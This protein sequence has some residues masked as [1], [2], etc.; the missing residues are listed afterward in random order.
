[1][2]ET[3]G[4]PVDSGPS[5]DT[6]DLTDPRLTVIGLLAETFLGLSSKL[7]A[8]VASHELG[9][10]EF[11][12]LMRLARSP[13]GALRMSD[14]AAQTSMSSSGITRVIDRLAA[15]GSVRRESCPSD[16]RWTYAVVSERGKARLDAALPGHV[17]LVQQWLVG[18]LSET[19][20]DGLVEAL[21]VVRDGVRPCA[22]AGV[23]PGD[24]GDAPGP[25]LS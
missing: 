5:D 20:L 10:V 16:R 13:G 1:M 12:V 25:A 22:T 23:Q 19:Q 2:E 11:E 17:A 7:G 21:R 24:T 3:T 14:L 8:Q 6:V 4:T 18:P 9:Q 15:D